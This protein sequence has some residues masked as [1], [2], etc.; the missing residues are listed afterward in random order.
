MKILFQGDS[1][2]DAGRGREI[3][4]PNIQLGSGYAMLAAA[5]LLAKYPGKDLEFLNRGI[6]GNRV[7]DLYA[8]WKIDALNLQPDI[9]SILV[10]V[11]DTWHE[12]GSNN[13]VEPERYANIYRMLL[14]WTKQELPDVKLVLMEPFCLVTG[15][16]VTEAWLTEMGERAKIV[17]SLAEEF[18]A[19]YVSLQDKFNT[20][21]AQ[22]PAKYWLR[23]GVH[24][25]P[26]G[27][28][29]IADAWMEAVTPLI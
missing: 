26:A 27:C 5:Q 6:S 28:A 10:G 1:I 23:D 25:A 9:I 11:N 3:A 20:V 21:T 24:P 12:Y 16:S 18:G 7:V 29:L 17:S 13:G 22:A 15:D 19:V 2:T 14:E 8:R 4:E